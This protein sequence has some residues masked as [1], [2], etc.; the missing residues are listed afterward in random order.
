MKKLLL[1][2]S[3]L[4]SSFAQAGTIDELPTDENRGQWFQTIDLDAQDYAYDVVTDTK[5][6]GQTAL[7]FELRD[8]D[9]YTAYPDNPTQ[10][11][12]DC[13]LDRERS[14]VRERW[15]PPLD[16]SVW[17]AFSVYIPTDYEPMYPKQIFFQWHAGPAPAIYYHLNKNNF[18]IDI[19][20]EVGKTTTQYNLGKDVLTLGEWHDFEVNIVWSGD[21]QSGRMITYVDGKKIVDYS[22]ATLPNDVYNDM[23]NGAK[24][25]EV[26]FGIYR[27]HLFR[28]TEPR[29]H[30]THVLY[31]DEYRR[32]LFQENVDLDKHSG[33]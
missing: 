10:G 1:I 21:P 13:T 28:W 22:G 31:F 9:C 20:T 25:P 27:S 29:P 3:L 14:E 30:P 24:T 2:C 15:N 6:K 26:K 18:N 32:G 8:G 11:W 5:R 7:R 19:L 12:N 16:K 4:I 33:D 23:Q 17:Y